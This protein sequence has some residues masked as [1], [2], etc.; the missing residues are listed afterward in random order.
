MKTK[1]KIFVIETNFY[2]SSGSKLNEIARS[3]KMI[4]EEAKEIPNFEFVWITDGA[5]WKD[6]KRNLEETFIVLENLY[7]I[8]DMENGILNRI[9]K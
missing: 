9:F 3:Y 5:G 6:A 7:N 1:S 8:T 4:A 2:A